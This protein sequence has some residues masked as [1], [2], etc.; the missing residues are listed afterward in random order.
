MIKTKVQSQTNPGVEYHVFLKETGW[1][2]SCPDFIFRERQKK[3]C[4]HITEIMAK[5][6]SIIVI[7]DTERVFEVYIPQ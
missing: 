2:C 1:H 6:E 3:T 5:I 4:K 7:A